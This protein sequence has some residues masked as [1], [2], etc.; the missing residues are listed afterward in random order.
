MWDSVG[1]TLL[2]ESAPSLGT[3]AAFGFGH[4]LSELC[5]LKSCSWEVSRA[6]HGLRAQF[7]CW[8]DSP[9]P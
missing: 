5:S 9:G 1:G 2:L 4:G 7:H 8:G 6:G 3:A